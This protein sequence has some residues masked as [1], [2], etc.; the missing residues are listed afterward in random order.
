M[1]DTSDLLLCS[2]SRLAEK[3]R[4]RDVT[5]RDV[6]EAHIARITEVNP[7]INAVVV[8]RF[9]AARA[10]ADAC[11]RRL[12]EGGAD[13]PPYFGVPFTVKECFALEGM[14][15]TSGLVSRVGLRAAS[16]ATVVRR[17][18]DAGAIPFGMTNL[19]ELCMWMESSNKVYGRSRNPYDPTRIVGGSSGGEGAVVG[20]GASPFGVGADIGGSIRM[21]AFFNGVFGHKPTGGLVPGTGQYPIAKGAALRY[22]TTGPIVRRAEDLMPLLRIMAGPDGHD[23]GCARF[24]LGDPSAVDVRKLR[25]LDVRSNGRTRV[26]ASLQKAQGE[27][28]RH[29]EGL[30]CEVSRAHF[31]LLRFSFDIW[32]SMLGSAEGRS[33]FR[34][35]LERPR[36]GQVL[37]QLLLWFFGRSPHT[38]PAIGLALVEN[39]GHRMPKRTQRFIERGRELRAELVSALGKDGVMLYPSFPTTAPRHHRPLFP[40]FQWVYTAILNVMELPVTQVPLGLDEDGL[41]LGVQVAAGPGNDHLTIAV[42]LELEKKFGGWVLPGS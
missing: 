15:Q 16:D 20:A 39:I 37:W 14:P 7:R 24:E 35:L 21:P 41:P 23:E 27:V 17:V 19:S 25:V 40:P 13:L 42:G 2:G 1:N 11:D 33:R 34:T 28:A 30:G 18:R 32:S 9:E 4:A 31:S 10:E 5:S 38:L 8:D 3:I 6:L 22:L 36:F 26:Q 12:R 29:L